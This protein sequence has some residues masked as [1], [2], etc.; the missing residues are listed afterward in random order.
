[1]KAASGELPSGGD[2]LYEIKWDGMRLVSFIDEDGLRLQTTNELNAT[3]SFPELGGLA[4]ALDEMES[5]ILDGEVVAFGDDG[6]PSFGRLQERMHIK[7][8]AEAARRAKTTPVSYVIFDLLHLNGHDTMSLPLTDRRRLLE[9]LVESGEHWRLSEAHTEDPGHLLAVVTEQGLE[10]LIAKQPSSRYQPGKRPPTWRK[11][12][13]RNRQ[14]FVVGGWAEGREGRA[15]SVG[16]LLLGHYVD[17]GL[18]HCGSVG[19]GLDAAGIRHWDELVRE[20]AVDESPFDGPVPPTAGR[21]FHWI[22]PLFVVEVAFGEW[23][24]DGHLR[25]P[26]YLGQRID[27]DPTDVVREA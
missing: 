16:S 7:D 27:K 4:E 15:G 10:G 6:R 23:T 1:M 25:H 14:E 12:K 11:I 26:S 3:A 18:R 24:H 17:G 22:E 8:P 13:P 5:V 20:H 9:Q 2:W 19:S 21:R